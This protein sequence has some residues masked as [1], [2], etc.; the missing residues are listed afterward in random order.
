M[1]FGSGVSASPLLPGRPPEGGHPELGIQRHSC[2]GHSAVVDVGL[3][4]SQADDRVRVGRVGGLCHVAAGCW[5]GPHGT[6]AT[7]EACALTGLK[8]ELVI[9][10]VGVTL[11]GPDVD[12][13]EGVSGRNVPRGILC[14]LVVGASTFLVRAG[15]SALCRPAGWRIGRVHRRLVEGDEGIDLIFG[16]SFRLLD[17]LEVATAEIND[18]PAVALLETAGLAAGVTLR[19]LDGVLDVVEVSALVL[20]ALPH[21]AVPVPLG[22]DAAAWKGVDDVADGLDPNRGVEVHVLNIASTDFDAVGGG[23]IDLGPRPDDRKT[24]DGARRRR[25]VLLVARVGRLGGRHCGGCRR[26][27]FVRDGRIRVVERVHTPANRDSGDDD[28]EH[29]PN[30]G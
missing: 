8:K 26:G 11:V 10:Q 2:L 15:A 4:L 29:D 24:A 25:L 16:P 14:R 17:D 28:T 3:V 7:H 30:L 6:S 1:F 18:D 5:E 20:V 9:S 21:L 12:H 22:G 13:A 23:A 19:V 27:R